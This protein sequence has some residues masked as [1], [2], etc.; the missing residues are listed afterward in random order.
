M[1]NLVDEMENDQES[2]ASKTTN[3][4]DLA[5][6]CQEMLDLDDQIAV[7]EKYLKEL[8]LR[9]DVISSEVIPNLLS[10][11]GLASLKLLD[12]STV[13]VSKKYSCTMKADPALKEKA[14]NWLRENNLGD[15]IK[16]NVSV[17]FGTGED[18]KADEFFGLAASNGYE[19]EQSEKVE[20]STLRALFRE[21][22]QNGLDM[23]SDIFNLFIKDETKITRKK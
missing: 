16:N 11:Q 19:P 1:S 4:Q 14:H 15:I 8:Q 12:G 10:E 6:K 18:T 21:R 22:V 9:R 2:F 5:S 13:E 7:Q 3:I 20:P 23:H 17:S